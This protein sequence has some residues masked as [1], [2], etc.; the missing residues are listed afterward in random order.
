MLIVSFYPFICLSL[1]MKKIDRVG[2]IYGRLTVIKQ[3]ESKVEKTRVRNYW[4]CECSCGGNTIVMADSLGKTKSCGCLNKEKIASLNFKH[5]EAGKTKENKAWWG[6]KARCYNNNEI[7]YPQYGGTVFH[8]NH[9]DRFLVSQIAP[10]DTSTFQS[11]LG[12]WHM[13][14]GCH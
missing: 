12:E 13:R 6:M 3:V 11:T 14:H 5:G 10:L 1:S 9:F 4:Y 2:K 7:K 8:Y